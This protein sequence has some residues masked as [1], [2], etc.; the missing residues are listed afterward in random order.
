MK[1]SLFSLC[2]APMI[3]LCVFR[4]VNGGKLLVIPID[5]SP[6]LS[7][8]SLVEK[9][10]QIG[11]KVVVVT[12]ESNMRIGESDLYT[13]KT[14]SIPYS[15][16]DLTLI[17]ERYGY[18]HFIQSDFPGVAITMFNGMQDIYK[19][20]DNICK[21]FLDNTDLIQSLKDEKFDAL[22]TDSFLFCGMIL[23]EHLDVPTVNYVRG[24]PCTLDFISAQCPS[25]FSYVPRIFT[26]YSDKMTF[27]Q[28]VKNVLVRMVE[29]YYCGLTYLPIQQIAS[30]F[31]KKEITVEQLLSRTSIW[32]Y[33]YDFVFEFPR[34]IMPNMVFVGG[35][36]CKPR[37][38]LTTDFETLVNSSGEHGFVVFSF[39]SMVSEIPMHKAMDIAEAL[40]SIPQ[41]VI[42]R[43]TGK[44]PSNLA[45]NTHLV[46]WLPQ[47]DLLAHP[48]AR[49]FITHA[50]S[51][52]LYESICNAVPVVMLPLFG[53]QMDNAKRIESRGAGV[54][55][56]VLDMTPD[57]LFNALDTVINNPS[58]KE[59]IQRLSTLHLDRPI[60][61]LDLAVYWVE[62]VMR[63]KGA[64]HLRP[65]AHDLNWIQYHSLDVF[66]FLLVVVAT[67]LFISFKCCAYTC[68]RCC[69]TK[70]RL[71]SKSKK[72]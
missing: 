17:F 45:N 51:H 10:A 32:L 34:P 4:Q 53:D 9:L 28:R 56:N 35:M 27:S 68:R 8:R 63:H 48:K 39:G 18:D 14:Y 71:K 46:K 36:N 25:P 31:L 13:T 62:F 61:P 58:Y 7:M 37:K 69:G 21:V 49:A 52:G 64:P 15:N 67:I 40:G 20:F 3:V 47:N 22:L 16:Q 66:G 30:N 6:W 19:V 26:Q 1:L 55:L 38:H 42:W 43:Y 70:S 33:R 41:T 65:A 60:H 24:M 12:G 11:H 5:G 29:P 54:I 23:A 72:E 59:N 2:S 57:D 50:G 44:V